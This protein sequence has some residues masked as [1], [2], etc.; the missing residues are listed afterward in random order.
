MAN[1]PIL[2]AVDES[3]ESVAAAA[4]AWDLAVASNADCELVHFTS[5]VSRMPATLSPHA[6]LDALMTYVQQ[7]ARKK[8][9]EVLKGRVPEGVL[10]G[11]TVRM[12]RP[13]WM[14]RFVV[15]ER[16]PGILV[17]GKKHHAPPTRWMGGSTVHHVLRTVD[18]PMLVV[19]PKTALVQRVLIAIDQSDVAPGV[20]EAARQLAQ[21]MGADTRV[22]HVVEPLPDLSEFPVNVDDEAFNKAEEKRFEEWIANSAWASLDRVVRFGPAARTISEEAADW[23]AD[24]VVVGTHGAG[25][26]DRLLVGS[27]THRLMNRLDRTMYVVPVAPPNES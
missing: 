12:G 1:R 17:L 11:M 24:L 4:M 9:K 7:S 25:W 27:T 8:M 6:D 13:A 2:A 3:S 20:L 26:L 14:L 21:V 15:D 10:D 23:N 18:V 16:Q 22:L 5:D 19:H